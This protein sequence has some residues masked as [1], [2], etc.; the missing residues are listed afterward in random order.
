MKNIT[1]DDLLALR[2]PIPSFSEQQEISRILEHWE[3]ASL[4][5]ENLL[6]ASRKRRQ[7]LMQQLLTGNRRFP[8]FTKPWQRVEIGDILRE[9]K[10]PVVWDDK[11]LYNLLSLRRASGGLFLREKLHGHEILTKKMNTTEVG[12]YLIS[13]MQVLHGASGLTTAKFDGMHVSDSYVALRSKDEKILDIRFF[14]WLAKLPYMYHLALV[15]SYGVHIEKM[16]FDLDEYLCQ[17]IEIPPTIEEQQRIV[18]ALD[19]ADREIAKLQE[20]SDAYKKQKKGLMQQLLTGKRR[21][22]VQ[23]A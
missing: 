1:Q 16:T 10:R 9:V 14:A 23:A 3:T 2:I 19:L 6:K 18:D 15:S 8:G 13:K 7:G 12:D 4:Y 22:K 21:V 20:V 5:L 17:H 11:N